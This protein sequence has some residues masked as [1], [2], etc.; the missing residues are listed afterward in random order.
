[1]VRDNSRAH[2]KL[3]P[4]PESIVGRSNASTV[5]G[6][7]GKMM[8]AKEV[9]D[10]LRVTPATIYRLVKRGGLPAFKVGGDWRFHA[11]TIDRWRLGIG[12][13]DL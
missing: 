6:I 5:S 11:D 1:M 3:V 12:S 7:S 9:A 10:F 8:T 2:I 13:Q 4:R